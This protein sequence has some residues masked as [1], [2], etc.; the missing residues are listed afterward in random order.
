MRVRKI[1]W[2]PLQ[3]SPVWMDVVAMEKERRTEAERRLKGGDDRMQ[4]QVE[5]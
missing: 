2:A 5:H 4:W 3:L 1:Y